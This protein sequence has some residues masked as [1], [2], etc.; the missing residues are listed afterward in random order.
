MSEELERDLGLVSVVA[1]S[2][3]AM[4]GSGIFILPGLAMAEAG[5]AVILAFVIAGLLVLPAAVSIAELG[6]AMPEA[7]GDY[8]F[9]ERGMG[10]GAGTIAGLGTWLMLMFKG[11]LALVGGML[12]LGPIFDRAGVDVSGRLVGPVPVEVTTLNFTYAFEITQLELLAVVIGILLISVN[13]VGVKQTGGLQK[14]LVL[15]ML[16]ILGG[17]VALT[18]GNI[19]GGSYDDFFAEGTIGLLAATAMVLISY[20][21]VTKV[22]AVAEEIEN[23]GRNLPLGLLLSL[24]LTTALYALIVFVLVG[25]VDAVTLEG[26]EV[27]MAD[28]VEPF[29]G[30]VGVVLIVI[31]AM[32][33]LIS[34][35][36]AGILTAS[37]YPFALSRDNLLPERFAAVS[38]R[39]RT[40]VIAILITG[41]AML[42]IILALPVEEI[43]KTA[44]AFQIVV[45]ILVCLSLIAFRRR[46]PDWYDPEFESPLYPWI[47]WFGVFAGLGILTQ[48]DTLPLIGGVGIVVLGGL[49]YWFYGR[50]RVE[51]TGLVGEAMIDAVEPDEEPGGETPFR[52]VVPVASLERERGL[53]RIAA[54]SAARAE[55]AELVAMNVIPV[56]DQTSLAQEVEYEQERIQRQQALLDEAVD[57]ARELG[58]GLRTRALVGRDVG[59][60]I[61]HVAEEE[62]ADGIVMGWSGTRKRRERVLGSNIDRVIERASCEVTL[63]RERRESVGDTVVFVGGGPHSSAAAEKAAA[64]VRAEDGASLTLVNVQTSREGADPSEAEKRGRTLVD[65][66]ALTAGIDADEYETRVVVAD[67][68]DSTLVSIAQEY[69]TTCLGASHASSV[70]RVLGGTIPD[71]IGEEVSGTIVLVRSGGLMHRSLRSA[72]V[73][74]LAAWAR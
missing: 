56:P 25:T 38:E 57:I 8:I 60:T 51:R 39:F 11:A 4:I 65:E 46:D 63:V 43:A 74:R 35:A 44:G 70:E 72:V 10:P 71:T 29:F 1:I 53:L 19:E 48:M 40:P 22:A 6:T 33:A 55:E 30:F 3:G 41:G 62:H 68:V 12:Y 61:L 2:M 42:V 54:A 17:F 37:R 73:Q 34:T 31:A 58:I 52:I 23:P 14:V 18:L 64:L 32:F 45:Y 27:P 5:P 13:V 47:Q 49:W 16:F 69:D 28:G 59:E 36:N 15:V 26:S 7:G 24:G 21:G 67:D 9:I 50:P 20:G 66:T